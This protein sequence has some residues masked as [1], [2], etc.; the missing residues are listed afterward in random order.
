MVAKELSISITKFLLSFFKSTEGRFYRVR[1]DNENIFGLTEQFVDSID[2]V[3]GNSSSIME[4]MQ[5]H[6]PRVLQIQIG[7]GRSLYSR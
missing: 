3:L 4:T 2:E 1:G 7:F 5:E 6:Q